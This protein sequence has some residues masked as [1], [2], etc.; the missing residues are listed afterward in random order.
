[1]LVGPAVCGSPAQVIDRIGEWEA[2][3]GLDRIAFYFD[4]GG[5]AQ[6]AVLESLERFGTEVIP[7]V[8]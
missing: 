1:M 4:L 7:A 3:L 5:M 6:S 8:R 2:M